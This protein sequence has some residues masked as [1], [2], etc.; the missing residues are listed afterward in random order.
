M[1]MG[2]D[3]AESSIIITAWRRL[4]PAPIDNGESENEPGVDK[5]ARPSATKSNRGDGVAFDSGDSTLIG[6][7]VLNGR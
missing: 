7:R 3:D 1:S 4:A 6:G 5:D 2:T